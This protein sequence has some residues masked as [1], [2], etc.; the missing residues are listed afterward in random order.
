MVLT[1]AHS[2]L[3]T[4]EFS[5]P[6][7]VTAIT[8]QRRIQTKN[9]CH[10]IFQV[11][12]GLAILARWAKAVSVPLPNLVHP[13]IKHQTNVDLQYFSTSLSRSTDSYNMEEVNCAFL[14]ENHV[15]REIICA[16][17]G[18]ITLELHVWFGHP[19]PSRRWR[20]NAW[21][22]LPT[23]WDNMTMESHHSIKPLT[24]M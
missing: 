4:A 18:R 17:Y 2:A 19:H 11:I 12:F 15:G 10:L 20:S 9:R 21:K 8:H 3:V 14:R 22:C 23:S 1:D 6:N 24:I 13:S 5:A 7:T 16:F